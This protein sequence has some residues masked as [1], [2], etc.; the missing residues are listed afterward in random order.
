MPTIGEI[1]LI[2]NQKIDL[3]KQFE[4]NRFIIAIVDRRIS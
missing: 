3:K 2:G 1:G 4:N